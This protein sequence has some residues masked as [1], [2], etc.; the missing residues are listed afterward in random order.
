MPS[1][2]QAVINAL[3]ELDTAFF[4]PAEPPP[5]GLEQ[6]IEQDDANKVVVF[7]K[8]GLTGVGGGRIGIHYQ[9]SVEPVR[10]PT[11]SDDVSIY[12]HPFTDDPKQNCRAVVGG[13]E[14]MKKNRTLFTTTE[15]ATK[16]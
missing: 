15:N 1:W 12:I 16:Y 7:R 4:T 2:I 9:A 14:A 10:G 5:D 3:P 6:V 11:G 13:L 8:L